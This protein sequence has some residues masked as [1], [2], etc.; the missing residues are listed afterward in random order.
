MPNLLMTLNTTLKPSRKQLSV[1]PNLK[2]IK[3]PS[4]EIIIESR[5]AVTDFNEMRNEI[6]DYYKEIENLMAAKIV[7]PSTCNFRLFN[8]L[9]VNG[10]NLLYFYTS[11]Q[12]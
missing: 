5:H 12:S 8:A 4:V 2:T 1:L 7:K 9:T 6:N 11:N 10:D 3:H